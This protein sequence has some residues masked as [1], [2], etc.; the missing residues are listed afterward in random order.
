MEK[1][2]RHIFIRTLRNCDFYL[3]EQ[4]MVSLAN[5][6]GVLRGISYCIDIMGGEILDPEEYEKLN[7]YISVQQ[8]LKEV[9]KNNA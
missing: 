9:D 6:I 1:E 5:E 2:L 7:Y 4:K 8:S 3:R